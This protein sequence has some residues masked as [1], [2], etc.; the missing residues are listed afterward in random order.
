MKSILINAGYTE[1]GIQKFIDTIESVLPHLPG[2]WNFIGVDAKLTFISKNKAT[3]A[4]YVKSEFPEFTEEETN[5]FP[6][7][8]SEDEELSKR[9][10]EKNE[11]YL[12]VRSAD[13]TLRIF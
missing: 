11:R 2:N 10:I 13:Q 5:G 8:F 9:V 7:I 6:A 12:A 3:I 4:D 1:Q